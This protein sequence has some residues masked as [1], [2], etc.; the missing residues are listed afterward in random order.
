MSG[1]TPSN[2]NEQSNPQADQWQS[3]QSVPMPDEMKK[4]I[5]DGVY[6]LDQKPTEEYL[7]SEAGRKAIA[8]EEELYRY[9]ENINRY[10][11]NLD[12]QVESGALSKEQAQKYRERY[13]AKK[14]EALDKAIN[15]IDGYR[16]DYVDSQ[17]VGIPEEDWIDSPEIFS[18]EEVLSQIQAE[19]EKDDSDTI[20]EQE[21]NPALDIETEANT[22]TVADTGANIEIDTK[23]D[24]EVKTPA[25]SDSTNP[26]TEQK[27]ES[28]PELGY[29]RDEMI[30]RTHLGLDTDSVR[31]LLFEIDQY[32]SDDATYY[33]AREVLP[34][35]GEKMDIAGR[36]KWTARLYRHV[37]QG[38]R[39]FLLKA[40][41]SGKLHDTSKVD[42]VIDLID[43]GR[44]KG[45]FDMDDFDEMT[46]TPEYQQL[47]SK[48]RLVFDQAR[49]FTHCR[50]VTDDGEALLS[51]NDVECRLYMCPRT[52]KMLGL[53]T[54]MVDKCDEANMPYYFKF[55]NDGRR[56]DR[57]IFYTN[58][59]RLG[60]DIK[61]LASIQQEHPEYFEDTGKNPLWGEVDGLPKGV[62]FGEEVEGHKRSYG[63][64]RAEAFDEAYELWRKQ[65]HLNFS[66]NFQSKD[67]IT[68]EQVEQFIS[69]VQQKFDEK[70]IDPQHP[71]FNKTA[72]H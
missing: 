57:V 35:N 64:I 44:R 31:N 16:Q 27:V 33:V 3:L 38:L 69:L 45:L 68:N 51:G 39:R 5:Q 43:T 19:K 15:Q 34:N 65:N 36:E 60:D 4:L 18:R 30:E 47:K 26:D 17:Q 58:Y 71:C 8:T 62:Y 24:D 11:A 29:S 54:A 2:P 7:T 66:E 1:E 40:K 72:N 61:M 50:N 55:A 21:S 59:G 9:S 52:D 46:M 63:E 28:E 37:T 70:G 42:E 10:L 49:T 20:T 12:E 67:E 22:D 53:M 25:S 32:P 13:L 41:Q 23:S 48:Q 6:G 14:D 56:N